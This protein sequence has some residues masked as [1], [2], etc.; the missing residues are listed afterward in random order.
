MSEMKNR[1]FREIQVSSSLL[2][3]IFLAV[4]ALGIFVFLLGV[5]VGKKQVKIADATQVVTQTVREPSAG[6]ASENV[7]GKPAETESP[8]VRENPPV[9]TTSAEPKAKSPAESK[10]AAPPETGLYYVQ[11]GAFLE[12]NQALALA[13]TYRKQGYTVI[14]TD[15]RP[16]DRQTWHRVRL[17]G[18]TSRERAEDLLSGLNAAAGRKTDFRVVRN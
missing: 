8:A 15:P 18:F 16:D 12:K 7:A 13:E 14:V 5:S 9:K 10:P 11:V 2:V 4:L 6:P 3:V 17:G 1:E